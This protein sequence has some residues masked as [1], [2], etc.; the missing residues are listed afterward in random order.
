MKPETL[1]KIILSNRGRAAMLIVAAVSFF[2]LGLGLGGLKEEELAVPAM[3]YQDARQPENLFAFP[4]SS[5]DASGKS[6]EV[7]PDELPQPGDIRIEVIRRTHHCLLYTS[8]C[9]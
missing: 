6:V 7:E 4:H 5:P 1:K 9:V 2:C 3:A 8:R